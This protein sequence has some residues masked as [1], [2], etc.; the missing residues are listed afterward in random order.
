MVRVLVFSCTHSLC[1]V[2]I[3]YVHRHSYKVPLFLVDFNHL[4]TKRRMFYLKTHPYRAANTFH[5]GYTNQSFYS[6]SG[7][8]RCLFSD[9]NKTHKY[10]VGRAYNCWM[11]NCWWFITWPVGF[12][13]LSFDSRFLYRCSIFQNLSGICVISLKYTLNTKFYLNLFDI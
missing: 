6:V 4:K 5:L 12:V 10:S 1:G 2:E 8:S 3:I 11:L 9:K 7:T 13:M